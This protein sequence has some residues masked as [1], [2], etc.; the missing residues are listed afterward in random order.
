MSAFVAPAVTSFNTAIAGARV[1]RTAVARPARFSMKTSTA[2]P[3]MEVPAPLE[4]DSIVGNVGF[5]PFNLSSVFNLK[6]MQEAEIKHCR[7]AM[8]GALGMVFPEIWRFPGVPAMSAQQAHDVL[9]KTGGMSQILL[10]V[11]FL[12]IFGA[13]ALKETLEGDRE[14]GYFG[15]DPLGLGK[16]PD[17]F[18]KYQLSE[19]KNGRLAMIAVGGLYHSTLVSKSGIIDQL[20]HFK[21]VPVNILN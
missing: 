21:G 2:M 10:F 5:D 9:V 13:I 12:E 16:N 1:C 6:F 11:S 4:D 14:P 7:V 15:F 20:T 19:I 17:V 3:F 18:K 8:L